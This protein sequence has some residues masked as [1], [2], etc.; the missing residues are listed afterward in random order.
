MD[1]GDADPFLELQ[2]RPDLLV[3]GCAAAGID[4]QLRTQPGYDHSYY[5]IASFVGD[6]IAHHAHWLSA[7]G[8]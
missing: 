4:L 1:Q 2:L 5:F 7:A 6:H 8:T 3:Q